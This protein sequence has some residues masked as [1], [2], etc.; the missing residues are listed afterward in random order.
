MQFIVIGRDF[1]D[2]AALDRRLKAR[3]EH[4]RQADEMQARGELLYAVAILDAAEKMVGSVMVT[5]FPDRAALDQW[6]AREPYV[7]GQVWEKVEITPGRV[8]PSFA[9]RA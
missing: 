3:A 9:R 2:A 6:L 7:L 4:L 8:G 5:E 1:T